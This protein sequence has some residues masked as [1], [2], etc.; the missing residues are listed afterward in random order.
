MSGRVPDRYRRALARIRRRL[1]S[2]GNCIDGAR[3]LRAI[4]EEVLL[5]VMYELPSRTDLRG[6]RRS[7]LP[8]PEPSE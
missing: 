6:Q 2:H 8:I 4:L 5:Q 1:H 7:G 3:G